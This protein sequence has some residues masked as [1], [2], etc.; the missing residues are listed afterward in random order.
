MLTEIPNKIALCS[1]CSYGLFCH[2]SI[3]LDF[4]QK[5][6]GD[7]EKNELT[8]QQTSDHFDVGMRTLF[9]LAERH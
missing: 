2:T 4:H 9:S 3:L 6:M 7:K 8:F 1:H 5:V